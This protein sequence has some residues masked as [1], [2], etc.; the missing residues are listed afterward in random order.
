M[1]LLQ[2]GNADEVAA[3]REYARPARNLERIHRMTKAIDTVGV[4]F[5][6]EDI[7]HLELDLSG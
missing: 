1:G 5:L 7:E 2:S 6:P 3:G 4:D